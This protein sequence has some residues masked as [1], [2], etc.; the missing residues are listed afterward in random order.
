MKECIKEHKITHIKDHS[1]IAIR[2]LL[3]MY[4]IRYSISMILQSDS[5]CLH[6]AYGYISIYSI[7]IDIDIEIYP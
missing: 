3:S 2:E 6:V 7:I 4:G 5:C 1:T